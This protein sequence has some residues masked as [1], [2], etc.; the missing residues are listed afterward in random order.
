MN[1]K[2]NK[3]KPIPNVRKQIAFMESGEEKRDYYYHDFLPRLEYQRR[4][5]REEL[6]KYKELMEEKRE[7]DM[8]ES[9]LYLDTFD[10]ILD[11]D[12][13]LTDKQIEL[14][15]PV[16]NRD[17]FEDTQ[18][19]R[20]MREWLRCEN[21][22]PVKVKDN[23]QLCNLLNELRR[24]RMVCENAQM[25][26]SENGTFMG[27]RGNVLTQQNLSASLTKWKR[28]RNIYRDEVLNTDLRKIL[29][30]FC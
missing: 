8:E 10:Y 28:V 1:N 18:T 6:R 22:E 19:V 12:C 13:K 5:V 14:L 2:Y 11:F 7:F 9:A 24:F 30:G 27:K 15:L 17:V 25:V 26:A 23:A 16:V 4:K 20:S 21:V 29:E 3:P